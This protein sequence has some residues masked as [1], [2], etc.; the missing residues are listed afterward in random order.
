MQRELKCTWTNG[1]TKKS[2]DCNVLFTV[3]WGLPYYTLILEYKTQSC[4]NHM[5]DFNRIIYMSFHNLH[6][7]KTFTAIVSVMEGYISN[8]SLL[9][10]FKII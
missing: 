1:S 9:L 8:K 5:L 3:H 7:L 4:K 6:A 2:T 10:S